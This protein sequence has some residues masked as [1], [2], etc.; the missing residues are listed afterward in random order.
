MKLIG[1]VIAI[2]LALLAV[3]YVASP[4]SVSA[5]SME[6]ATKNLD[7]A[8]MDLRQNATSARAEASAIGKTVEQPGQAPAL[9][10]ELQEFGRTTDRLT[11]QRERL[12]Q[13]IE[14]YKT[15][16]TAKLAEF[17]KERAAITNPATQRSMNVLRRHTEDDMTERIS[18][19]TATLDQL[20]TA[21]AQG[22]DLQHAAHCVLIATDLHSHGEDLDQQ[23]RDAKTQATTYAATT[24]TLLARINQALTD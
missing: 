16:Y 22:A 6:A 24:T 15:A 2:G 10:S 21:L 13:A 3:R 18:N 7:H 1:G 5:A 14:D 8:Q 4:S 12:R 20:D 23:L 19:A 9:P 11:S 17:D